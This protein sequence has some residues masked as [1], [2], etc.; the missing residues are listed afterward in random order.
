MKIHENAKK[1]SWIKNEIRLHE[2]IKAAKILRSVS[3]LA[4]KTDGNLRIP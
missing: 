3:S 1:T 2:K 4:L